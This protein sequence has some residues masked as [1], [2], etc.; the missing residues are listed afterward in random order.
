M[1]IL[2]YTNFVQFGLISSDDKKNNRTKAKTFDYKTNPNISYNALNSSFFNNQKLMIKNTK[3]KNCSVSFKSNSEYNE[4]YYKN[5]LASI[6]RFYYITPGKT[7]VEVTIEDIKRESNDVLSK[8]KKALE[9][10]IKEKGFPVLK[11][12]PE[13]SKK[14]NKNIINNHLKKLKQNIMIVKAYIKEY[15]NS[16]K[17]GFSTSYFMKHSEAFSKI[18]NKKDVL[19]IQNN[20]LQTILLKIISSKV[21]EYEPRQYFYFDYKNI[22]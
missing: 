18:P 1:K 6:I 2:N 10:N 19:K 12:D 3:L 22:V 15:K 21:L 4:R 5:I 14:E 20:I 7:N 13:K 9:E 16:M 11:I 17:S 8:T